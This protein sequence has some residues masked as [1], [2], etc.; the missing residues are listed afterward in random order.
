MDKDTLIAVLMGGPGS[1]RDVSIASG[2]AVLEALIDEGL[3]ALPVDVQSQEIDLPDGVG[4][5]FNAIHG[6]FGEDGE[7]Q[8]ILEGMGMPYTGAGIQS[9][10]IAF[11]KAL[12]KDV[13][14]ERGVPTPASEI[15][16]CSD[17]VKLPT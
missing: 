6:T 14:I 9:S 5:C 2:N 1:E 8:Q 10:R 15:V 16:D 11:D 7:M 13:F 12:S 3:N 17:G 4:L